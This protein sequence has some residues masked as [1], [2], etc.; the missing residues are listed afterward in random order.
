MKSANRVP[1]PTITS[2]CCSER[3][4]RAGPGDADRAHGQGMVDRSRGLAGLRLGDRNAASGAKV[5][6]FALRIGIEN[7]AAADHERLL[8][9]FQ[10]RRGFVDLARVWRDAPLAVHALFEEAC[11]I[12]VG[13]GLHV[14][15]EGEGHR[16]ALRRIGQH[17]D[18]SVQRRHDLLGAR[19][20]VEIPRHGTEAVVGAHRSVAEVLDLL[21]NRIGPAVGEDVARYQQNRQAVDMRHRRRCDHV[22]RAGADRGCAGHHALAARGFGEGDRGMG[23]RLFVVGA[24]GG[25][26]VAR[27]VE[28]FAHARHV[29]VA[30]NRE[31]ALEQALF[32]AVDFDSLSAQ[33]ANHRLSGGQPDR[34][35][36]ADFP[37]FVLFIAG[38]PTRRTRRATLN[39]AVRPRSPR[40][41]VTRLHAQSRATGRAIAKT[42]PPFDRWPRGRR[43]DP[44]T[45]RPPARRRSFARP[46][47][48]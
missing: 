31:H 41:G 38:P 40:A 47:S 19:D 30:E 33:E 12:V 4:G 1:T 28:R 23:H 15:A 14:L 16:P 9:R 24:V 13:L 29:A 7:A 18:R 17:R 45:T 35:H 39:Q 22:G 48:L 6:E 25:E 3:V 26:S 34:C 27:G 2:A 43:C 32:Q 10:K 37:A 44:R 20:A 11:R 5:D 46:Q 42:R 36:G 8:G 21:Q